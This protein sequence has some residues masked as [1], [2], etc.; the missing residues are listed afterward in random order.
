MGID[1]NLSGNWHNTAAAAQPIHT[2]HT[3][4]H[5]TPAADRSNEFLLLS[6]IQNELTE[7][8]KIL[9]ASQNETST[10]T[11]NWFLNKKYLTWIFAYKMYHD[12]PR[13]IDETTERL[14][15]GLDGLSINRGG[16]SS[17]PS[18]GNS[19]N[20][21]TRREDAS[22]SLTLTERQPFVLKVPKYH[23]RSIFSCRYIIAFFKL[24]C[25]IYPHRE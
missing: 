19:E 12:R 10:L 22:I 3:T 17:R 1:I 8:L 4:H 2:T 21:Q 20:G 23:T 25:R 6:M 15:L 18:T 16:L 24:L 5:T 9:S 13:E 14:L 7:L 11:S